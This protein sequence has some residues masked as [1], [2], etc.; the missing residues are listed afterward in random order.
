MAGTEEFAIVRLG[1]DDALAGLALSTE[2]HWNQNEADWRFFL[3]RGIV[4]GVRDGDKTLIASAAL[5]PYSS[6][7][8]WISMMLV[9]ESWRRRGLATRLVD[10]CLAEA[11]KQD[12][13]SWLDATPA[14]ATVYG[15]LGFA[16]TLQ[17]RRLRLAQAISTKAEAPPSLSSCSVEEFTTT[18]RRAM[19]F[20]RSALLSELGGRQGSRLLSNGE[21]IALVRDGRKALHIGP[22]YAESSDQALALVNEIVRSGSA[23][24]LIDAVHEQ[25]QFLQGLVRSGWTVER[26]F[27]RMR[28]GH[29]ANQSAHL[30]FAVAGPEYG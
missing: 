4:F 11:A 10:A 23:S 22:V 20:D 17:L 24:L 30:P 3:T 9:T 5:L 18:D 28:F 15:P 26:P 19:G 27:Q 7:N 1:A 25:E 2:A 13:V 29:A 8:A 21:A 12:L 6:G 16:P 14:G